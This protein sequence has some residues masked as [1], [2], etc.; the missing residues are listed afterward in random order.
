MPRKK[1]SPNIDHS[2]KSMR[3]AGAGEVD[4]PKSDALNVWDH[5]FG[6]VLKD[7]K[8]TVNTKAYWAAMRRRVKQ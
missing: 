6:W 1:G 7:G 2:K 4:L 5:E 3:I 8:P